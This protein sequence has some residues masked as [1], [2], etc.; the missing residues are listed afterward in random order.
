MARTDRV[1]IRLE[2]Q[3]IQGW[4]PV[5]EDDGTHITMDVTERE[6]EWMRLVSKQVIYRWNVIARQA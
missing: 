3:S 1:T 2:R 6:Y 4:T 5:L